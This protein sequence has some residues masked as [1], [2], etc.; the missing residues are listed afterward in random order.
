MSDT[1]PGT[2]PWPRVCVFGAGAVGCYFGARLAQAGA[3]VTL[4]GR[5]P[6]VDA[7]REHGLILES[8][9]T[10]AT[11]RVQADTSPTAARGA[12]MVLFC[13]KS[14]DT[15]LGAR[16]LTPLLR[17]GAVVVSLQNGVDNVARMREAAGLDALAAVVYVACSMS[18]PGQVRHAGRGDLILGAVA[19]GTGGTGRMG[20]TDDATIARIAACFE[21]AGVPCPVSAD[22]R[23]DLWVKLVMNCVFNAISALGRSHYARLVDDPLVREVMRDVIVECEAVARAD[24][25]PLTKVDELHDA[26]MRLGAAMAQATSSTAQDLAAGRPTEIDSLNGYI[27]RRGAALNVPVPV[28]R[29]LQALVRLVESR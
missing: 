5:G 12:D 1:A 29:A 13:V 4:V 20:R 14:R 24:G 19:G 7:I 28:N 15:D 25:V 8:A 18:G 26:A 3:E 16:T 11:V 10:R 21:R 17:P 23:V 22:V 27:A 6:H 2:A 9:G